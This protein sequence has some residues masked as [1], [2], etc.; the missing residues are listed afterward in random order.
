MPTCGRVAMWCDGVQPARHGCRPCDAV[1]AERS[2]VWRSVDRRG[3]DGAD[4]RG[5]GL[6]GSVSAS[7]IEAGLG[8]CGGGTVGEPHRRPARSTGGAPWKVWT[9]GQAHVTGPVG[10]QVGSLVPVSRRRTCDHLRWCWRRQRWWWLRRGGS[11][12]R[13]TTGWT[14][15]SG[16]A[17]ALNGS[18]VRDEVDSPH[19]KPRRV[20]TRRSS[21]RPR[22]TSPSQRYRPFQDLPTGLVVDY[23]HDGELCGSR[24]PF[25]ASSES[26]D[27]PVA[28]CFPSPFF[29]VLS[30]T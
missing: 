10:L 7:R 1:G 27:H 3:G 2:S 12:R 26:G 19:R 13:R 18:Y 4:Q 9:C 8:W 16:S 6:G 5:G 20:H 30:K 24:D 28:Y 21:F 22:V 17:P 29:F 23:E 11:C 14:P 15:T 25:A